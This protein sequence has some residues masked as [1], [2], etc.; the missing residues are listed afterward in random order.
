MSK[1][2]VVWK[3]FDYKVTEEGVVDKTIVVCNLGCNSEL[4][5]CGNTT[6]MIRHLNAYHPTTVLHPPSCDNKR[7]SADIPEMTQDK[8]IDKNVMEEIKCEVDVPH[9]IESNGDVS[10][11]MPTENAALEPYEAIIPGMLGK[12]KRKFAHSAD[13]YRHI[14]TVEDN[15]ILKFT[16]IQND[17]EGYFCQYLAAVLRKMSSRKRNLAIYQINEILFNLAEDD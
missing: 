9:S 8:E 17:A 2:S 1:R 6:N 4:K 14:S 12:K 5:L 7:N 16:P 11:A 3:Y 15:N 10:P 13:I